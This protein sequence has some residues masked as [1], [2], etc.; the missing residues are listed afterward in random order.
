MQLRDA[1]AC[2]NTPES[3]GLSRESQFNSEAAFLPEQH[4]GVYT[5]L[6][7]S[8]CKANI[9][10]ELKRFMAWCSEFAERQKESRPRGARP[11]DSSI[12]IYITGRRCGAG[13]CD[14]TQI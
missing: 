6:T 7:A 4:A 5:S 13:R 11:E 12:Y 1:K 14:Y 3:S 10:R 8:L 2:N 9:S